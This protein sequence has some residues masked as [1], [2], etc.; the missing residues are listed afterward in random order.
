MTA[1]NHWKLR[2]QVG[3]EWHIVGSGMRFTSQL[4]GKGLLQEAGN[5]QAT[6]WALIPH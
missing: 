4:Y 5:D 6:L 1:N 3:I 2:L